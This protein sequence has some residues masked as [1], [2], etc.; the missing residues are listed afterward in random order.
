MVS[1]VELGR[2]NSRLTFP[3]GTAWGIQNWVTY[4][5]DEQGGVLFTQNKNAWFWLPTVEYF[6]EASFRLQ[7]GQHVAW[8]G[9][10]ELDG[11]TYDLV[12]VTWGS[13]T[14][15]TEIDQYVA[16][17]ERDTGRLGLL[18]YTVRDMFKFVKGTAKYKD[19]AQI[20]GVLAPQTIEI[21][22]G[23]PDGEVLHVMAFDKIDFGV[24]V[25]TG[26]FVPDSTKTASKHDKGKPGQ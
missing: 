12:Y 8:A 25:P 3:D 20:E 6:F 4:E 24:D 18:E 14:P 19:Y 22:S 16:W 2:D 15:N 5:V 23:G 1:T 21:L 7:E 13:V 17:I 26:Y 9:E 10:R 11:K